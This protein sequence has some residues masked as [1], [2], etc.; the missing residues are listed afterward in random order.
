MAEK[1]EKNP[2]GAGRPTVEIGR[3]SLCISGSPDQLDKLRE[4]AKQENKTVSRYVLEKSG[5]IK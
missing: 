4:L 1:T 2:K 3:T 5:V